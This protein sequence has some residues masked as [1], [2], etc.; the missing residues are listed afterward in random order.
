VFY[1]EQFFRTALAG[2]DRSA[3]MPTSIQIGQVILLI[4][5]LVAVY[6]S[7]IRGGDVRMLGTAGAKYV[8]LGLVLSVYGTAFRDVNGMFN[9]FSDFI[10]S[11]TNGGDV[12]QA[13]MS[14][15][16]A[17]YQQ[18]GYQK[19]YDLIMGGFAA[20][21][22]VIPM[23]VAYVVYP[24]T[25]TAFCFF[26]SFYGAVLYVL[27]PLVIALLPAF[28]LGSMARVYVINVMAFH[29][30]GVIYSVLCALMAAVNLSTVQDVLNAGSFLGGFVG[31]EQSLLLGIASIFYS[32]SIAVIPFLASRIVRG[33]TFG[34]IANVLVS[35]IPLE[36]FI[37]KVHCD[38]FD[39][40]VSPVRHLESVESESHVAVGRSLLQFPDGLRSG[41]N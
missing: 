9:A 4:S 17:V 33:E 7:Y 3:I 35:K 16:S 6:E 25:Y 26:Y 24:L 12:F 23:L 13:W 5:F 15:L 39:R 30:W 34:T 10:A 29:F 40:L 36:R 21:L 19:L 32:I 41:G 18:G 2:I 22:G 28:G 27:G 31:L 14:D 8:A 20:I 1:Y 37:P 38:G 11:T